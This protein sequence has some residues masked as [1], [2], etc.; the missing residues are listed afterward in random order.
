MTES[1]KII[2][3]KYL[4]PAA[5]N[6]I[7]DK[8]YT[9]EWQPSVE[10]FFDFVK[11][12]RQITGIKLGGNRKGKYEYTDPTT[13]K[14][15]SVSSEDDKSSFPHRMCL[16]NFFADTP[17]TSF[18][19]IYR[20]YNPN[21]AEAEYLIA[22]RTN[23][24]SYSEIIQGSY[25][26]SQLFLMIRDLP[27]DERSRL[28]AYEFPSLW[29][30][31]HRKLAEGDMYN[32][33]WENFSKLR[34]YLSELFEILPSNDPQ[35]RHRWI[36]PKGRPIYFS[37][38]IVN[39]GLSQITF[40]PE[41]PYDCAIREFKEETNGIEIH[42]SDLLFADPIVE[43]YMGTNSKNYRTVYFVF[44]TDQKP[45]ITQFPLEATGIR[46]ASRDEICQIEWVPLSKLS[47][48]MRPSQLDLIRYIEN[49]LPTDK[50]HLNPFW[51]TPTDIL[52][53]SDQF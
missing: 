7:Y 11:K 39:N 33:A 17:I 18:G 30:D 31:L 27:D 24:V 25:R 45:N 53:D 16:F 14:V 12:Y 21:E 41:S 50:V 44:T 40:I 34:K 1:K 5:P 13:E 10:G 20:Y 28:L 23:S 36:F 22:Q 43:R 3:H 38:E 35:G 52:Q 9:V 51:S 29:Y 15:L 46:Q 32:F 6:N 47:N 8:L 42:H 49:H 48:Y 2:S 19:C 4:Y 26:D 37:K